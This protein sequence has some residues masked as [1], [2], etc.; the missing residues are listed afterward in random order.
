MMTLGNMRENFA[1]GSRSQLAALA[2]V[3]LYPSSALQDG[4]S[5]QMTPTFLDIPTKTG[6]W[7]ALAV[8]VVFMGL[9]GLLYGYAGNTFN[10]YV[11]KVGDC[12]IQGAI[13]SIMFAI[14]KAMIDK[15]GPFRGS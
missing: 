5:K 2:T 1:C 13:I 15:V 4:R 8:I 10:Q 7:T 12:F 6:F 11:A 14:L 9:A 3:R